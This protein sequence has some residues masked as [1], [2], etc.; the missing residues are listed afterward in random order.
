ML[1]I[2]SVMLLFVKLGNLYVKKELYNNID[3][4]VLVYD[5]IKNIKKGSILIIGLTN[6]LLIKN[7]NNIN[8]K[9]IFRE[10]LSSINLSLDKTH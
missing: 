8:N 6:N 10:K 4:Y 7:R 3:D 9:T 1:I 2:V 5:Y